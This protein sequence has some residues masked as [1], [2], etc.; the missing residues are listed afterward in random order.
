MDTMHTEL[1]KLE[2]ENRLLDEKIKHLTNEVQLANNKTVKYKKIAMT[3]KAQIEH[4]EETIANLKK[5]GQ[6]E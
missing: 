6:E 1:K 5:I 3:L 2:R 4:I